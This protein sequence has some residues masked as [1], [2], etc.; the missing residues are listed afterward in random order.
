M[1]EQQFSTTVDPDLYVKGLARQQ[2]DFQ[3]AVGELVDNSFS[4]R[5]KMYGG[6]MLEPTLV[7][8][9]LERLDSGAVKLQIADPGVGISLSEI[10]TKVFNLGGQGDDRGQL[11]E[12]GFGLKNALALLTGGNTTVFSLVTRSDIDNLPDGTFLRVNGPLSTEMSVTTDATRDDW[13]KDLTYLTDATTGTKVIVEVAWQYFRSIYRRG[14]PGFDFLV[15][16]IG[17]H[18]GV[19]HRRFI[20][21]GNQIKLSYRGPDGDWVF[22][23]VQPI[24]VPFEGEAKVFNGTVIVGGN[25]HPYT[26]TRGTLDYSVKDPDAK[27][28]KGWPYPLRSYY[29]G[30]NAR[31]GIDITVRDR[32]IKNGVFEEVWPDIA[33][34]VDF[35]KFTGELNVGPEF[36][37]TNN[38]TGL[39]PHA[40]NWQALI[41][42]L[43]Q[44]EFRPEK[45][46]RSD[47]E[48]SLRERLAHILKGTFPYAEVSQERGVWAGSMAIDIFVDDGETNRR[49]YELK[50]TNGRVVDL[51][52][53]VAA[54]DGLVK[55]GVK[56]TN[57]ILVVKDYPQSLASAVEFANSRKDNSGDPYVI[58]LRKIEELV[59]P[60]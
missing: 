26:Y 10:T 21:A 55:E 11:N 33:K 56:P 9:T 58:E 59:P 4:A 27:T 35:N 49:V 16:R 29:Q 50:I 47:S 18:L 13:D 48:K 34:T 38:K 14:N 15:E 31:C 20:E 39:D 46:T 6:H 51:Y 52:Q 53:L 17:E 57:G 3:S 23:E 19:M 45:T 44:D 36:R 40:E 2:L 42:Q 28:E 24:P 8:I 5:R 54:W 1:A 60:M 12:H 32:V 22:Q 30:S 43:N 7:E 37:T 25:A 41:E